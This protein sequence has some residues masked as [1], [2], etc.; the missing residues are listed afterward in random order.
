MGTLKKVRI[1]KYV[2]K[3]VDISDP[4]QPCN[5]LSSLVLDPSYL[6]SK[7]DK[8]RAENE[9]KVNVNFNSHIL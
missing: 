1:R 3:N 5:T 6:V 2:T 8:L 9:S 4:P 7:S